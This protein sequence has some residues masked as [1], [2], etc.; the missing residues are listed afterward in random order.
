MGA[1]VM[2]LRDRTYLIRYRY[3]LDRLV[4]PGEF[5][6]SCVFWGGHDSNRLA[7]DG[8]PPTT[9]DTWLKTDRTSG[10]V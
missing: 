10:G 5:E 7:V 9:A 3:R 2:S 8:T 6:L 1:I 4:T